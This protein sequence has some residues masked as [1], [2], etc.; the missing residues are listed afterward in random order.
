MANEIDVIS[1]TVTA[2]SSFRAFLYRDRREEDN[3]III[4]FEPYLVPIQHEH[5]VSKTAIMTKAREIA[6][7]LAARVSGMAK[8]ELGTLPTR[9]GIGTITVVPRR[10]RTYSMSK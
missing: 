2:S 5:E 4:G 1:F 10:G 6:I 8:N 9:D 7:E 3:K